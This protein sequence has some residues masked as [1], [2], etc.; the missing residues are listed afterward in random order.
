LPA[1]TFGD[2][3]DPRW[4]PAVLDGLAASGVKAAFFVLGERVERN[5]ALLA[6]I[7]DEGHDVQVHGY[8]HLRHA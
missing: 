2:G 6:R 3:P 8:A 4:T 7:L 5:P 1:L